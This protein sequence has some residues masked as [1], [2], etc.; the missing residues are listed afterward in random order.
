MREAPPVT[1]ELIAYIEG[2]RATQG[3]V[4]CGKEGD[5]L[6]RVDRNR[7]VWCGQHSYITLKEQPW[8]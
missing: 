1:P 2:I 4:Q 8:P 6:A 7:D 3:C 5:P